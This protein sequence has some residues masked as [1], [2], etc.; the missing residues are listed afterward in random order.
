MPLAK[1]HWTAVCTAMLSA[2]IGC[3][4]SGTTDTIGDDTE[5]PASADAGDSKLYLAMSGGGWRAHTV[6]SAIVLAMLHK[7]DH[8]LA[9]LMKNVGSMSCNSGGCWFTSMLA[10]SKS[11]RESMEKTKSAETFWKTGYLGRFD[12]LNF[13]DPCSGL[14]NTAVRTLCDRWPAGQAYFALGKMAQ[15]LNWYSIVKDIVFSP[16]GMNV[17]LKDATLNGPR[18]DW[19]KGKSLVFAGSLLTQ[20]AVLSGGVVNQRYVT[21]RLATKHDVELD[22]LTSTPIFFTSTATTDMVPSN[23][24]SAGDL[25]LDYNTTSIFTKPI[26]PI[27]LK[28]NHPPGDIPVLAAATVSSAAAAIAASKVG[29]SSLLKQIWYPLSAGAGQIAFVASA[30]APSFK[31]TDDAFELILDSDGQ[32]TVPANTSYKTAANEKIVR[33]ADGGYNDNTATLHLMRHLLDNGK[34]DNFRILAF[35]NTNDPFFELGSTQVS[36]DIANLFGEALVGGNGQMCIDTNCVDIISPQV[37]KKANADS[38]EVLWSRDVDSTTVNFTEF[39]VET[40][41]NKT[42]GISA[43][44]K[45]TLYVLTAQNPRAATAPTSH[46]TFR[47]YDNMFDDIYELIRWGRGW[48]HLKPLFE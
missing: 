17:A 41:E 48:D 3:G 16:Y 36:K 46:A 2:A 42:F 20:K 30:L 25:D 32:N 35:S 44:H 13:D 39:S 9:K 5:R 26:G 24:F 23:L 45:G 34:L 38:G 19:A 4:D 37:F 47:V 21:T 18:E 28:A 15:G 12:H 33:T 31:I 43:G 11:F 22:F 40:V 29:I 7:T 14:S 1:Y 27:N 8:D 10:Y 6:D